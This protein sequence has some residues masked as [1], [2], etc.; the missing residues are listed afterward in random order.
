MRPRQ[1]ALASSLYLIGTLIFLYPLPFHM[2][3]RIFEQG[4][5]YL[6]AWIFNWE[7]HALTEAPAGFFDANIFFPE[8]NT[9]AISE[10]VLPDLL[11]YAPLQIATGN[12][13][14]A[15]NGTLVATFPLSALAMF[16]LVYYLT[17][18][19]SA[20]LI[21]GFIY[22]FTPIRLSHLLHVQL[23]SLMWLPLLFLFFHR[24][25]R[26]KLWRD[27]LLTALLFA[28]QY[29]TTVYLALYVAPVLLLY[30]IFRF[31]ADHDVPRQRVLL[32]AMAAAA[33]AAL[34]IVPFALQYRHLEDWKVQPEESLKIF[35]SSDLWTNLFAVFPT[36]WLYGDL[37]QSFSQPPYEKFYFTGFIT[38]ALLA[39][40]FRYPN[41]KDIGL[42]S[43][44]AAASY[45]MALGPFLRVSG[46]VTAV[47][48]PYRWTIDQLP[49][50]SMLRV[51]ARA[52][53]IAFTA[54]TVLA[55][56]GWI[57]F[58]EWFSSRTNWSEFKTTFVVIVLL[59]V[60]FF[61]APIPLLAEVSGSR[62]PQVYPFL[63]DYSEPGGVLEI[64]TQG[65]KRTGLNTGNASTR[66]SARTT[67]SLSSLVTARTTLP[68]FT[69]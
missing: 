4:D 50:F 31:V 8:A 41:R 34:M 53:I 36:N 7:L 54:V 66:I 13:L 48:L 39:L 43:W 69:N 42:F 45:L 9:L 56:F 15:Y 12:P 47:P 28:T 68:I 29:L 18:R 37:F 22:G 5:S 11:I 26:L 1:I 6:H 46:D 20:A 30:W 65:K 60:E 51:P 44:I 58:R 33:L 23:E 59:G 61:S 2:N 52:G 64:P 14:V 49:G 32:Q 24:W 21:G 10:V 3:D 16:A 17:G 35:Y 67:K 38:I 40:A 63:K 62:V 55:A 27:A 19:Y 57:K 25:L